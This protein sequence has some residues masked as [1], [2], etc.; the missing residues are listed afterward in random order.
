MFVNDLASKWLPEVPDVHQRLVAGPPARVADMAC[1]CGWSSISLARGY[2][3][4]VV[5]GIDAD[6][7][8]VVKARENAADAGVADRVTFTVADVCDSGLE[9]PYDAAFLFEALHDL[10]RPVEAL[11][12]IGALLGP[13]GSLVVA[14]E[15][16]GETFTA[17]GDDA[18]RLMYGFSILHCLPAS[19]ATTP[20]AAIGTVLRPDAVRRLA[21]DAGFGSFDVLPIENDLWRFYRLANP[22]KV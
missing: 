6:E 2:P 17:P 16:V 19:R 12:S 14:D 15:R 20:S 4:V 10:A 9:G 13:R 21:E 7:Q 22:G 8:S 1:G 18:E 11:R 5:H 3:T